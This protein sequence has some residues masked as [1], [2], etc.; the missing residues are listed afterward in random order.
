[1][2]STQ[3]V[4]GFPPDAETFYSSEAVPL[5]EP[6]ELALVKFCSP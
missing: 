5:M 3:K 1:M 6:L 4:F 2:T